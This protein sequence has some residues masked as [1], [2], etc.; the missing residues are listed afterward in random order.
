MKGWQKGA[1]GALIALACALRVLGMDFGAGFELHADEWRV[2]QVAV[3]CIREPDQ[4]LRFWAYPPAL[5]NL[6]SVPLALCE[7]CLAALAS[8]Q[9]IARSVVVGLSVLA[10]LATGVSALRMRGPTAGFFALAVSAVSPL[11]VEQSRYA[12]PD[13]PTAFGV[14]LVALAATHLAT[15]ARWHSYVLAGC[16]VGVAA[17]FKYIGAASALLIVL[18]HLAGPQRRSARAFACLVGAGLASLIT[19]T[20]LNA[21][22]LSDGFAPM[23]SAIQEEFTHYASKGVNGYSSA[24]VWKHVLVFLVMYGLGVGASLAA[25]VGLVTSLLPRK[26][27]AALGPDEV[28]PVQ[29]QVPLWPFS[30][31]ALAWFSFLATRETFFARNLLHV[32]PLFTLLAGAGF[33][34]LWQ[35]PGKA[36]RALVSVVLLLLAMPAWQS[37]SFAI[38]LEE[39]DTRIEA[40]EWMR[41]NVP[42]GARV[43]V[44]PETYGH[45]LPV[46]PVHRR[47]LESKRGY[48][49]LA[50]LQEGYDFLVVSSGQISRYLRTPEE[51]PEKA[52]AFE[53]WHQQLTRTLAPTRVFA[54]PLAPGGELF[55]ATSDAY[56]NPRIEIFELRRPSP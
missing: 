48:P 16:S 51:A 41:D 10:C 28:M 11:W 33:A 32:L 25:L 18:V 46:G 21:Q 15:S 53:N 56:H 26:A 6:I 31:T 27:R 44:V 35:R 5:A 2:I 50:K 7:A 23:L 29:G 4:P 37:T 36:S 55:G 17:S 39:P 49:S 54:R 14:A 45:Y 8:Q 1:L 24:R 38:L 20:L 34:A 40:A 3:R 19:F 30:V 43:A 47:K 13:L 42:A 9:L 22:L 52:R 12:T